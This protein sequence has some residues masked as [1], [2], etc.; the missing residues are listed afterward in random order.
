M[1][2]RVALQRAQMLAA[3]TMKMVHLQFKKKK[4]KKEVKK[5]LKKMMEEKQVNLVKM[6]AKMELTQK[7]KMR[8]RKVLKVLLK[9]VM[10]KKRS[11]VLSIRN[12][13][14]EL[15]IHKLTKQKIFQKII[16]SYRFYIFFT[17][18]HAL[19]TQKNPKRTS[20]L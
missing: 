10:E 6:M 18:K 13:R 11:L 19:K 1:S 9:K 7:E 5:V 16:V 15:I 20:I 14:L 3:K 4:G 8:K 2:K 17:P 12:I